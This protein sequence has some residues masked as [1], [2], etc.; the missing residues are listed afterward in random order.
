MENV[1]LIHLGSLFSINTDVGLLWAG[2]FTRQLS[3]KSYNHIKWNAFNRRWAHTSN[4]SNETRNSFGKRRTP[5]EKPFKAGKRPYLCVRICVWAGSCPS[6]RLWSRGH[7]G[8]RRFLAVASSTTW[9]SRSRSAPPRWK[10]RQSC[11]PASSPADDRTTHT[12]HT[13]VFGDFAF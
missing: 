1:Q 5:S 8:R 2:T 10:R 13:H 9:Q 3:H 12:Y 7:M 4:H 6:G 11:S